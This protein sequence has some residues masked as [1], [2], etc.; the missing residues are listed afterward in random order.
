MPA[1]ARRRVCRYWGMSPVRHWRWHVPSLRRKP[2]WL[3]RGFSSYTT[4]LNLTEQIR[5]GFAASGSE[6]EVISAISG[7]RAIG[8]MGAQ[9]P[10]VIVVDGEL[11]G[12]DGYALTTQIKADPAGKD[13]PVIIL[14]LQPN[15]AS[16]LK[17]RQAGA[18]AHM[19]ASGPTSTLVS[20]IM[21]LA[22]AGESP[23]P[24]AAG[25]RRACDGAVFRPA[26]RRAGER[27]S[28]H[29][30]GRRSSTGD[31]AQASRAELWSATACRWHA[32]GPATTARRDRRSCAYP[33]ASGYGR[34][35][36]RPR[37]HR[38][39]PAFDDRTRRIRPSHHGR[40]SS[41]HPAAR[42]DRPGREHGAPRASRHDGR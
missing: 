31:V 3:R 17:A 40:Q 38:R 6:F 7:P 24:Q 34:Y 23:A 41:G 15:E 35:R 33:G 39:S 27:E 20:K 5:A 8:M 29:R 28:S 22:G 14:S 9:E 1:I 16:A 42:R 11:E 2:T 26:C 13:V 37:A 25:Q 19:S 18:A 10:D 4:I 12:V 36:R 30:S 21:T 32:I